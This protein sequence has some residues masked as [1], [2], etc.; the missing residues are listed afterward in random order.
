MNWSVSV[1]MQEFSLSSQSTVRW[2]SEKTEYDSVS[3]YI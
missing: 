3:K 2:I 1:V